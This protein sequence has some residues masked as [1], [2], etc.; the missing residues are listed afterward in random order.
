MANDSYH[1]IGAWCTPSTTGVSEEE[2]MN[3]M[4]FPYNDGDALKALME[5]HKDNVAAIIITPFKHEFMHDQEMPTKA[6]LDTINSLTHIEGPLLIIDDVRGGFRLHMGGSGEYIGLKPHLS[7][8]SKAMGNGY[9]ISA[10]CGHK[11][12]MEAAA[13]VFFTG[14]FFAGAE[15]IAASLATINE[16]IDSNGLY[17]AFQA[18][19]LLKDGMLEQASSLGLKINYTGPVT[20]PFMTFEG[21]ETFEKARAFCAAGFQEGVFFHP[22][23]NWFIS[24]AH[25]EA[26]IE[27]TLVA[28]RK[29]FA[30][31]AEKF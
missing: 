12:L 18:G 9:P 17:R 30:A 23:H 29:A 16:M 7:C 24:A 22:Y 8:F 1:G 31:V 11:D 3:V 21:D 26:D 25:S 5:M 27:E 19:E 15:A 10:L 4:T 2:R 13:S 20:I 14:S 28:T 6:F